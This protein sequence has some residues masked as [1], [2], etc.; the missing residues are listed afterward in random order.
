VASPTK[1]TATTKET[2]IQKLADKTARVGILGMGYV[3]M[4]LAVV[5]A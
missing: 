1:S 4:P 5:F 3:G 2:L